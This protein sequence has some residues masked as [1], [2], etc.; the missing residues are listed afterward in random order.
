MSVVPTFIFVYACNLKVIDIFLPNGTV[1]VAYVVEPFIGTLY[2]I[3]EAD[4]EV[5]NKNAY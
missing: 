4:A 5:P 1:Y 2:L 3:V